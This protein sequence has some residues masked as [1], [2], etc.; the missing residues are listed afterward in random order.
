[1]K[2][3]SRDISHSIVRLAVG[4]FLAVS[5]SA[6][7]AQE[8]IPDFYREP[9][10]YPTR[11]Y[12]NQSF[13]EH[14]D[15]LTGA[16]Q[17]HY[18]D[19]LLPGNGGFDLKVVRSYNS[20]SINPVNPSAFESLAG[21]GWTIHFGRVLK[22]ETTICSNLNALSVADNPVL[23]LPDGGR[24]LLAFTGLTSPLLLSTQRWRADCILSGAGGLA[25]YSPDGTRYDM[26][27]LVNLGLGPNPVYAW[28]TTKITDRNGN[29]ADISYAGTASPQITSVFASDG[30]SI[31][32]NYFDSGLLSRRISSITASGGQTF[33]YGYEPVPNVASKY[34][35][36][37]VTRPGGTTWEYY[38][39]A[40]L[41]G[42]NLP[43]GIAPMPSPT[44]LLYVGGA[45]PLADQ[46]GSYVM[47]RVKYPE[48]GSIDYTY[49]WA[50]FD[51][52]ANPTYR[53]TVV[54]GKTMS[55]GGT[56]TFSYAPGGPG[57]YDTTTVNSPAGT[58][59]Y[60]HVGPNYSSSG[61]VWMVGLL[62]SKTIGD[63]Q[64][65]TYSWAGQK[66]SNENYF[67]PGQFVTKVDV[68]ATNAPV[69]SQRL[70]T[71][72][73]ATYS[74]MYSG[75]DEHG[76]PATVTEA[77][78]N[79]GNRTTTVSYF[80]NTTKWII[81]QAKDELFSGSST[82]RTFDS[83]NGNLLSITRDGVT[84][85]Y[86]YDGQGNRAQPRFLDL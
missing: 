13:N 23:E 77:G 43:G 40:A 16:L 56:W 4:L 24:Q 48:G 60:R 61:T 33:T 81:R 85:S 62:I 71:R 12:V 51:A 14:I 35:L 42:T 37:T 55:T 11:S 7:F 8:V 31:T 44:P 5:A 36:K 46:A 9:G 15:P 2:P 84:T 41:G 18:V 75:F 63:Q 47:Y 59:T 54:V 28:Y 1:M 69:L 67:R 82:T 57:V 58:T 38:Y 80:K 68:G 6:A 32:F 49:G 22:T 52:Q 25:V 73:G 21:L 74:T 3:R 66:I 39:H 34:F 65:E 78:P 79:G 83:S 26:T 19:L 10:L 64:I 53:A 45:D 76:N 72:N 20:A 50:Y 29:T 86:S 70:I 17:H 27:Q 30:R